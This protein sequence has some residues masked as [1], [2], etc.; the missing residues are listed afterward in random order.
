MGR[1][2]E[3]T[4]LAIVEELKAPPPHSPPYLMGCPIQAQA[5]ALCNFTYFFAA[6]L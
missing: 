5:K 6:F 3:W 1:G 2:A 4:W